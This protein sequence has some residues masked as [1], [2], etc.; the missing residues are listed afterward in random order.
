MHSLSCLELFEY[1]KSSMKEGKK[2]ADSKK[3]IVM[4]D[5]V[6]IKEKEAEGC[7][8]ECSTFL[9][10]TADKTHMFASPTPE[11]HSWITELCRLAFPLNQAEGRSQKAEHLSAVE[12]QENMLYGT[13]ENVR[14]FLVI[15]VATEAALRCNLYGE[16]FLTP[17]QDLLLLK[18]SKT[19]QVLLTW[20]YRFVRKFGQDMLAFNFEAGRRC[21]SGEGYFEFATCHSD[22]VFSIVSEALKRL[23]KAEGSGIRSKE[24][25]VT[26]DS[27][28]SQ[29]P[30]AQVK[31]PK[32]K[33]TTS[34][35][36]SAIYTSDYSSKDG[37]MSAN[38][39]PPLTNEVQDPVYARVKPKAQSKSTNDYKNLPLGP[40]PDFVDC[41]EDISAGLEEKEEEEDLMTLEQLGIRIKYKDEAEEVYSEVK[42]YDNDYRNTNETDDHIDCMNFFEPPPPVFSDHEDSLAVSFNTDYMLSEDTACIIEDEEQL[43]MAMERLGFYPAP[44]FCGAESLYSQVPNYYHDGI[45]DEGIEQPVDN[46]E[47]FY[48][49]C[50]SDTHLE[51]SQ[52]EGFSTYDNLPKRS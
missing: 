8:K 12:M 52:A 37:K 36:M 4:R 38:S 22:K 2:R 7:P 9:L 28:Q 19:K 13:T 5:C 26:M 35:S 46:Q 20:P 47:Y 25:Q 24:Q 11:L 21:E 32:K 34:F 41:S 16:Y 39:T 27:Q 30:P 29:T 31:H 3:V 33:L 15:A 43:D 48:S 50:A 42:I 10:E 44:N 17:Q 40:L 18:D 51:D 23:P 1:S 14:D 6:K 45:N 49:T